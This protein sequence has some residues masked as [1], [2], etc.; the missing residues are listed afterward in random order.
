GRAG[1]GVAGLSGRV[2]AVRERAA[3]TAVRPR[4][5]LM[6][7]V[8]PLFCSGH[9]GPE[10]VEIAGG[11]DPFGRAHQAS[12]EI[13]WEAVLEAQPEVIVMALCGYN[14]DRALCDYELIKKFPRFD[15]LLAAQK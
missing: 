9:W 6:E 1:D 2:E 5:F 7:W 10:L 3:R 11:H 14:V 12:I 13:K 15:S 8:D 4:C